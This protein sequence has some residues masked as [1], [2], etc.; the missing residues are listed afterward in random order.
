MNRRA[1]LKGT[2]H[3]GEILIAPERDR[4]IEDGP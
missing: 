4:E 2:N 1:E 3:V